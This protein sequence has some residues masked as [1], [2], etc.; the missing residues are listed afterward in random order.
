MGLIR[1]VRRDRRTILGESLRDQIRNEEILRRT[2]VTDIAQ[3]LEKLRELMDIKVPRC[4]SGNPAPVYAASVDSQPG[5]RKTSNESRE[6]VGYKRPRILE[7]ET[8][9]K[10]PMVQKWKSIGCFDVYIV[11]PYLIGFLFCMKR[12]QIAI[13]GN[14]TATAPRRLYSI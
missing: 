8:P 2:R 12:P 9:C 13:D 7:F 10:R 5:G 4:W 1:R 14:F 6:A 11:T 3:R